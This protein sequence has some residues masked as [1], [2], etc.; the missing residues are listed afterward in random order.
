MDVEGKMRSK[1][2]PKHVVKWRCKVQ[3]RGRRN[4]CHT[5]RATFSSVLLNQTL[6]IVS[7]ESLQGFLIEEQALS[8]LKRSKILGSLHYNGGDN[9]VMGFL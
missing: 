6:Q 4:F 7:S 2:K 3:S 5:G 9:S 1:G 8:A